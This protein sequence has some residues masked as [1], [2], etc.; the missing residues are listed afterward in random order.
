[1]AF[2]VCHKLAAQPYLDFAH[3]IGLELSGTVM[4]NY[5]NAAHQLNNNQKHKMSWIN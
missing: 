5:P 1:M 4:M 3:L 2:S